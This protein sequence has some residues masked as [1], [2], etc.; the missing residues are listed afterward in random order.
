MTNY[1]GILNC[2]V[3]P[4]CLPND[5]ILYSSGLALFVTCN[6]I[7]DYSML[8]KT[9]EDLR[10]VIEDAGSE[11]TDVH[12]KISDLVD[13]IVKD[14]PDE[15]EDLEDI[16]D[17][18][19]DNLDDGSDGSLHFPHFPDRIKDEE[20]EIDDAYGET[21]YLPD[22]I[23]EDMINLVENLR[24][25]LEESESET[26]DFDDK[27]DDF[28]EFPH[29]P[30]GTKDIEDVDIET[31]LNSNEFAREDEELETKSRAKRFA[32]LFDPLGFLRRQVFMIFTMSTSVHQPTYIPTY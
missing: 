24:N 29:I 28:P 26:D 4:P 13:E 32:E 5:C 17:G 1:I 8:T 18:A 27:I 6:F 20:G 21:D 3:T 11:L 15:K 22:V 16:I 30:D 23:D 7:S 9:V 14:L 19:I 10:G 2:S 25:K 31:I 12:D